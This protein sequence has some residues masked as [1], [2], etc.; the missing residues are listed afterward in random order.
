[1]EDRDDVIGL[2]ERVPLRIGAGDVAEKAHR[3]VRGRVGDERDVTDV[4]AAR[5][6]RYERR[7]RV[8]A[9]ELEELGAILDAEVGRD[10]ERHGA[11]LSCRAASWSAV[12]T[13]S[14]GPE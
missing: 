14:Q 6:A 12:P 8:G 3:A 9:H 4:K 11:I 10:I 2:L 5:A 1:M 7:E 13:L